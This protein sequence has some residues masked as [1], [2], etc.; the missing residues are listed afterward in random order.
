MLTLHQTEVGVT[1]QPQI[2][3]HIAREPIL[4]KLW[5]W[6]LLLGCATTTLRLLS[7]PQTIDDAYITFHYAHNIAAGLGYYL[8]LKLGGRFVK[9]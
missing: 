9:G 2:A 8:Q 6:A 4:S 3:N 1:F 7:G 5:V